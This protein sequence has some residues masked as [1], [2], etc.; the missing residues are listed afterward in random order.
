MLVDLHEEGLFHSLLD[1]QCFDREAVRSMIKNERH[2]EIGA[3]TY[4]SPVAKSAVAD[5][6]DVVILGATEIDTAFNVNVHTDSN[7][8]IMGGSGGHSDTAA[9]ARLSV[10]VAPLIRARLPLIVD[11]VGTVSTPG[12]DIDLLVTQYGLAC[13]P[14]KPE[15]K[16]RLVEAGLPVRTMEDLKKK[17]EAM[18]GVP[19]RRKTEGRTVARVINRDGEQQD[20]IQQVS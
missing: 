13:N 15:L 14:N 1:V 4:A 10:I 12:R 17:A 19:A 2:R 3:S 11:R 8:L 5:H 7:G 6:L 9:G 18:A 20:L 16:D